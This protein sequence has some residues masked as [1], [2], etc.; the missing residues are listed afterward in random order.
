MTS[1]QKRKPVGTTNA[2]RGRTEPKRET[3]ISQ[4]PDYWVPASTSRPRLRISVNGKTGGPEGFRNEQ[5]GILVISL[6]IDTHPGPPH[7][8]WYHG[9]GVATCDDPYYYCPLSQ[10]V[11]E[12]E[13]GVGRQTSKSGEY[14]V[15]DQTWICTLD[16][17]G[18]RYAESL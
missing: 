3:R 6:P 18:V 5:R 11:P 9:I 15:Q 8:K 17:Q 10:P 4:L 16:E 2:Q 13:H 1:V 7:M 14:H 12:P